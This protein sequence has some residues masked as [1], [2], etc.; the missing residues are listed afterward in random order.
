MSIDK[1][2]VKERLEKILEFK[3]QNDIK[4]N[5]LEEKALELKKRL[6]IES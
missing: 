3:M 2:I 6:G 1:Q 4:I 5:D